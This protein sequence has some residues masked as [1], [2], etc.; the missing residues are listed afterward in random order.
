[1]MCNQ[2]VFQTTFLPCQHQ[3][4]KTGPY[5]GGVSHPTVN[6]QRQK[7]MKNVVLD[8]GLG[9]Y[10]CN[11][12]NEKLMSMTIFF[13]FSAY[14]RILSACLSNTFRGV[15]RKLYKKPS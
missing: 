10:Q 3:K 14:A 4:K 8:L 5:I 11:A 12:L 1:M 9:T 13:F 15:K 7:K 2:T 6:H